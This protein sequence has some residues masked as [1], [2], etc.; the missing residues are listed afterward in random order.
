MLLKLASALAKLALAYS[1]YHIFIL[2]L[3]QVFQI[4]CTF[5]LSHASYLQ[6]LLFFGT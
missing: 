5:D 4:G 6:V 2:P 1:A 3:S